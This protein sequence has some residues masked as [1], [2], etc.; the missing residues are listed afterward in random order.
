M[1]DI[2]IPETD[3]SSLVHDDDLI[4]VFRPSA[5]TAAAQNYGVFAQKAGD[6]RPEF[7]ATRIELSI[8]SSAFTPAPNLQT[9]SVNASRFAAPGV[10]W[11]ESHAH[12][13]SLSTSNQWYS[14]GTFIAPIDG[15]A[16]WRSWAY[17]RRL[18]STNERV[19]HRSTDDADT[20]LDIGS[21]RVPFS[22]AG[23]WEL[24][25]QPSSRQFRL[26]EEA[27][28]PNSNYTWTVE[29]AYCLVGE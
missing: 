4:P 8:A 17:S 18:G 6:L 21:T 5:K 29:I 12:I 3:D 24:Q 1:A 23:G 26:A 16:R 2:L 14:R 13:T 20:W 7:R 28:A 22:A 19:V 15:G 25:Y 9:L 11:L 10:A 27:N